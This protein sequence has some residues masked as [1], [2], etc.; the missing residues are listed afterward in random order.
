MSCWQ[1]ALKAP[2]RAFMLQWPHAFEGCS[3]DPEER[4]EILVPPHKIPTAE[5][6]HELAKLILDESEGQIVQDA[7]SAVDK[8]QVLHDE[9]HTAVEGLEQGGPKGWVELQQEFFGFDHQPTN[10][11]PFPCEVRV[12]LL[13]FK[14]ISQFHA[15]LLGGF[16]GGLLLALLLHATK[17]HKFGL[18]VDVALGALY[19]LL[20]ITETR[21]VID[22]FKV[23]H[24]QVKE[25][26]ETVRRTALALQEWLE[27][28]EQIGAYG[29]T[30]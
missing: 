4:L 7:G 22:K 29:R 9:I 21:A 15:M 2:I 26:R 17:S 14:L 19:M 5:A 11:E 20:S 12:P 13:R 10:G 8:A 24:T 28:Y 27:S 30:T 16:C 23:E 6:V 3:V 1:D 25:D 18:L